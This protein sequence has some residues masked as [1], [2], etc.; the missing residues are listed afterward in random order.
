[1]RVPDNHPHVSPVLV[2]LCCLTIQ[3]LLNGVGNLVRQREVVTFERPLADAQYLGAELFEFRRV[4][5]F[6]DF[7]DFRSRAFDE[8]SDE[9]DDSF[10]VASVGLEAVVNGAGGDSCWVFDRRN[11]LCG[12]VLRKTE[13]QRNGNL[14]IALVG[15][16]FR[17]RD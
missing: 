5:F 15:T 7:L 16:D 4:L 3:P 1:M 9:L 17:P 6:R 8:R 11:G 13:G 12:V 2:N 10:D 14:R